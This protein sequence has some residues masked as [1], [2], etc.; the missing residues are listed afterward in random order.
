MAKKS[1]NFEFKWPVI[2]HE[3]IQNYL[4]NSIL[5]NKLAN[6]YLFI[7]PEGVGKK[8]ILDYFICSLEC[9]SQ[10][11]TDNKKHLIPCDDCVHCEQIKKNIHPDVVTIEKESN[12]TTISIEQI[13]QL[14]SQ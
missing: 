14:Q 12:K 1:I 10:E 11:K 6:A 2:G 13:R 3:K 5:N 9:Y 8:A 7:G 4:Q